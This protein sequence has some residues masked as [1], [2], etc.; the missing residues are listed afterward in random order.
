MTE[1]KKPGKGRVFLYIVIIVAVL[2]FI[3]E[4]IVS[5]VIYQ[6]EG[7]DKL[8]SIEAIKKV[9]G[10]FA[11]RSK[12]LDIS[13]HKFVRPDSS[14]AVNMRIAGESIASN[15]FIHESWVEFRNH[16]FHGEFMNMAQGM[17]ATSPSQH[18]GTGSDTLDIYFFGG[19]TMF[20]F[21]VLD[22]ETIPSQFVR[23]Y[24]EKFPNGK[25]I[26]VRNYGTP[27]YYSYQELLLFSN[28]L[29]HQHKPSIA[30]FLDGVNDFWFVNASYN[31]QSY[32]SYIF[33]Q[34]FNEG[35]R[36]KGEFKFIDSAESMVQRPAHI[37]SATFYSAIINNYLQNLSNIRMMADLAGTKT[38]FF[39][40]PAPFY[41]YPNQQKD[42]M[43]FKQ[44]NTRFDKIYPLLEQKADS[45]PQ[46]T[47][48]GNMLA[49]ETGYPFVD[50]LH[51]GP[52]F[53]TKMAAQIL[54]RLE[55]ELAA[56]GK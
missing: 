18:I 1:A 28:L 46:F 41:N 21:N 25:T 48:L 23:L 55:T 29:Y 39:L 22:H 9:K 24:K 49:S 34:M 33:R 32:F 26:R 44:K 19:S 10:F 31:R 14:E 4:G 27:M 16:D 35:L 56:P 42:P 47:F 8:A 5:M 3:A 45:I 7:A 11:V 36:S 40:Q 15:R 54:A 38:F 53:N 2:V 17:R 52:A 37:D 30:V 13:N 51:Y 43:A 20:G 12:T 6:R 50:G